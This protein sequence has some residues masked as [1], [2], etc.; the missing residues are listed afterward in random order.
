VCVLRRA[1]EIDEVGRLHEEGRVE[2]IAHEAGLERRETAGDLLG[3][4]WGRQHGRRR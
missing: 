2:A 4:R 3:G 1:A